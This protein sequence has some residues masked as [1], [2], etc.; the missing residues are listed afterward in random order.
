MHHCSVASNTHCS[1]QFSYIHI[2]LSA[3]KYEDIDNLICLSIF[4]PFD[5][6][7]WVNKR[8]EGIGEVNDKAV[9]F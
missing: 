1:N 8:V 3:S 6:S 4:F 7:G 5:P 9:F 2:K